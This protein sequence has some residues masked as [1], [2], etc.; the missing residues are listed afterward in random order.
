MDLRQH[1]QDQD[2]EP[3]MYMYLRN[4]RLIRPMSSM[5]THRLLANIITFSGIN[6][7]HYHF[8][9]PSLFMNKM[10]L[11]CMLSSKKSLSL[12]SQ[13]TASSDTIGYRFRYLT[14]IVLDYLYHCTDCLPETFPS[15]FLVIDTLHLI[16]SH[17]MYIY[18]HMHLLARYPK[19]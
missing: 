1:I 10:S 13:T 18:L 5:G 3:E 17:I 16:L 8:S 9:Q 11:P 12:S 4:P 2:Q 19:V 15:S 6:K 7:H 14:L